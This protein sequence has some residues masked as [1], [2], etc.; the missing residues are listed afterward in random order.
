[1]IFS[2]LV[3]IVKSEEHVATIAH[4]EKYKAII[5]KRATSRARSR[6][7]QLKRD[8]VEED[9]DKEKDGTHDDDGTFGDASIIQCHVGMITAYSLVRPCTNLLL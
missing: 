4:E 9:N 8:T 2:P 7:C 5:L 1:V 3:F 6:M